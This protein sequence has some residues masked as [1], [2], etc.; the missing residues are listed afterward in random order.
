[1]KATHL[2]PT[3]QRYAVGL[4]LSVAIVLLRLELN[5][6][7]GT[8]HNRHLLFIPT[9][10]LAA[11]LG[12]LGPGL[13]ASAVCTV[14]LSYFW[15]QPLHQLFHLELDLVLFLAICVAISAMIGS[16]HAARARAEGARRSRERVLEI[17]A[18]DLRNPLMA[19]RMSAERLVRRPD[20]PTAVGRSATVIEN[21]A[22]R[23]QSLISDLVDAARIEHEQLIVR[24]S[25]ESAEAIVQEAVAMAR[26][27]AQARDVA[28]DATGVAPTLAID[29]DRER[30][31]QVLG[32]LL[33]NALRFTP[34]GG[35]I[36]VRTAS[37]DD[38]VRFEVEDTGPGIKPTDRPHI[39]ER[40]W[41]GDSGGSGL[42]LFIAQGLVRA[43]GGT[44]D[45]RSRPGEGACFYFT[46]PHPRPELAGAPR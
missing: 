36:I 16:L 9:V 24:K 5:P 33:G 18:H 39:F 3:W 7:W 29:C 42:G 37:Q 34:P 23:M 22:A 44:L 46:I 10:M 19:V 45:V 28:I 8:S 25:P 41:K 4:V 14:A 21:A 31:L 32:N 15:M 1:M 26:P 17:V 27:L 13:L 38:D 43:H 6:F 12:G 2:G 30:I 40:Y 20:D 11:W 35:R